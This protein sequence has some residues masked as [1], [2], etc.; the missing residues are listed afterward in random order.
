MICLSVG[1]IGFS[2]CHTAEGSN[3]PPPAPPPNTSF[4]LGTGD[5][6]LFS[7]QKGEQVRAYLLGSLHTEKLEVLHPAYLDIIHRSQAFLG[8][9]IAPQKEELRAAGALIGSDQG[10]ED[11]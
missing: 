10:D 11:V 6:G 7:I 4:E 8:E 5:P 2:G 9:A 3:S 1:L